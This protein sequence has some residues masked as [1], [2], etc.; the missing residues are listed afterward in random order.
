MSI[1][2][3]QEE[4]NAL[5]VSRL[6]GLPY[7]PDVAKAQLKKVWLRWTETPHRIVENK[8]GHYGLDCVDVRVFW[9]AL[10]KELE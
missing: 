6:S 7:P 4:I 5:P 3:T 9:E 2:L 10:L 1:L 8:Q